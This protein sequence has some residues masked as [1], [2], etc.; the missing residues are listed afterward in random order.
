MDKHCIAQGELCCGGGLDN[1]KM[2]TLPSEEEAEGPNGA[3]GC[4][5]FFFLE[6]L[7]DVDSIV[8]WKE[9]LKLHP[10]DGRA[11]IKQTWLGSLSGNIR[12]RE[13]KSIYIN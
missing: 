13:V 12:Q 4:V 2:E 9:L 6:Q 8:G 11:V 3:T 7:H 5:F 10:H 1:N